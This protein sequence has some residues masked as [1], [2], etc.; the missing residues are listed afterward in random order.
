MKRPEARDQESIV[1]QLPV[2]VFLLAL[3]SQSQL[4]PHRPR[5][6]HDEDYR[7]GDLH[8]VEL[9]LMEYVFAFGAM[10]SRFHR[11]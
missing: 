11:L 1:S 3:R 5:E 10:G 8:R 4:M 2:A 7:G 9:Y 6:P